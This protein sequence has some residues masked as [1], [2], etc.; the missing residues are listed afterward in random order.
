LLVSRGGALLAGLPAHLLLALVADMRRRAQGAGRTTGHLGAQGCCHAP[1]GA[2]R[3]VRPEVCQTS[4]RALRLTMAVRGGALEVAPSGE[5]AGLK[6]GQNIST[7]HGIVGKRVI[8]HFCCIFCL[9]G[10]ARAVEWARV[11][12]RPRSVLL[13]LRLFLRRRLPMLATRAWPHP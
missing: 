8:G 9:T 11:P 6:D 7:L 3:R 5:R 10:G 2:R 4:D 13:S 12:R 1:A